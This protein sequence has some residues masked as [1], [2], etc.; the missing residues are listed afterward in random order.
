MPK[1]YYSKNTPQLER[2]PAQLGLTANDK[3]DGRFT[4]VEDDAW[5]I[6]H[7]QAALEAGIVDGKGDGTFDPYAKVTRA[8]AS[9]MLA[10]AIGFTGYDEDKLDKSK[11][12]D[13]F[14]DREKIGDWSKND[15]EF[16][17][18]AGIFSGRDNGTIFDPNG[19]TTR[20]QTAVI[21]NNYLK[22]VGFID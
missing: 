18:E 20:A 5:Y 7:L 17:I 6:E 11:T 1:I 21:L 15:V 16:M 3:Y 4:D 10:R 22:F 2:Q 12:I 13:T 14:S 9:V 8:Q 19:A